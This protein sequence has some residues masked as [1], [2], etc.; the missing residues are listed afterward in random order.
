MFKIFEFLDYNNYIQYW[1]ASETHPSI[2]ALKLG[3]V[4]VS[5]PSKF[6]RPGKHGSRVV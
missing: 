3:S 4:Y 5:A 2:F 1:N 6:V